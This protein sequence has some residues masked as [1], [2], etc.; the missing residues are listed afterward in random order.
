[1]Q[2]KDLQRN[3]SSSKTLGT[4]TLHTV[5]EEFLHKES[6]CTSLSADKFHF[7]DT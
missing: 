6:G 3:A 5:R 2:L 1:M 4:I 7:L